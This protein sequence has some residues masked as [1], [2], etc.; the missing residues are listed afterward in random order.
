MFTTLSIWII[1]RQLK[2]S[3]MCHLNIINY[4]LE[5]W[6]QFGVVF[7]V[8]LQ[9]TITLKTITES[10]TSWIMNWISYLPAPWANWM[11][12]DQFN[13]VNLIN[14]KSEMCGV[15]LCKTRFLRSFAIGNTGADEAILL[16]SQKQLKQGATG[17]REDG[18]R[19]DCEPVFIYCC[20]V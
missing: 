8:Y 15:C 12:I 5:T 2:G 19:L 14:S 6:Q 18:R 9:I 4:H 16:L 7:H 20:F 3:F 13:C 17:R 11:N 1:M 10:N